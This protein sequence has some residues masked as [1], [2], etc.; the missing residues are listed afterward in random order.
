MITLSLSHWGRVTQ[1]IYRKGCAM[2]LTLVS[3]NGGNSY[4]SPEPITYQNF[5]EFSEVDVSP[6]L[7]LGQPITETAIPTNRWS[8]LIPHWQT[9]RHQFKTVQQFMYH[10]VLMHD[11][12]IKWKHFPR[13]WPFVRWIHWS[14]LNSPHEGRWRGALRFS[15]MSAWT[16]GW[17]SNRDAGDLTPSLSL[18]RHC[19]GVTQ[20]HTQRHGFV[21]S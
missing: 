18:W 12:V 10:G 5:P 21:F 14:P 2:G 17:I 3:E 16:N 4:R 9:Y 8:C 13:C 11:D 7:Y 20:H 6:N 19:N 1:F 15:L